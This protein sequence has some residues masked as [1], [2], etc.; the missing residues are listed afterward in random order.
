MKKYHKQK[1]HDDLQRRYVHRNYQDF[2]G[3]YPLRVFIFWFI[4]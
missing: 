1:L 4:Y 2:K 3:L